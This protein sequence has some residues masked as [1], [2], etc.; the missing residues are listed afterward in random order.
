MSARFCAESMLAARLYLAGGITKVEACRIAGVARMTLDRAI[1]RIAAEQA[2]LA[3]KANPT[4]E[5]IR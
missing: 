3:E 2:K 5:P 4:K 1:R